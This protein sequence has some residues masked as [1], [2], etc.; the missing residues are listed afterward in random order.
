MEKIVRI[1][2]V[3]EITHD[4][5]SFKVE[6]PDGY[7]FVPGQATGVSINKPEFRDKK[8]PFTFTGL[9]EDPFLEFTIKIYPGHDGVT[10]ELD[11][12]Q[13]GDELIIRE[14]WGAI[15]YKGTGVF[16]AGGAGITPFIAIFR[17][18]YKEKRLEGN[19][20]IFSNKTEKDIILKEELEQK[21]GD[22][23]INTITDGKSDT[24]HNGMIDKDFLQQQI[25]N[26]EQH[27]YVCGPPAFNDAVTSALKELGAKP[28]TVV[29]E[30]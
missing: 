10:R 29:I 30:G 11:S 13:Q 15:R 12:L 23:F 16:I 24:Y 14:A 3:D 21:L 25:D 4:V 8:N 2:Q 1:L 19:K 7:T 17:H 27:F 6:K 28:D 5:K 26:F 20:L 18:L 9:N 22:N